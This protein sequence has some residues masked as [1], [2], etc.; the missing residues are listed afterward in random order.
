MW[1]PSE[2]RFAAGLDPRGAVNRHSA[3]DASLWPV[4]AFRD[5][6]RFA[7]AMETVLSR[8]GLPSGAP[9]GPD[10]VDFDDDRD[11][12]WLEGTAQA[13]LLLRRGGRDDV[14]RRFLR[15]VSRERRP[16]GWVWASSVPRL[17]TGFHNGDIPFFYFRRGHLAANAWGAMAALDASPFDGPKGHDRR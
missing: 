2:R 10:G 9:A 8:H 3:V 7:P 11:G 12:I 15:T 13:A 16:D 1:L 4:L 14:A 17:T 5:E 6:G